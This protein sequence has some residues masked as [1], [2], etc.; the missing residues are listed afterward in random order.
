MILRGLKANFLGDSIT[1]G[2]GLDDPDDVYWRRLAIEDGV[3]ARGYGISGT[4][5]A[6]QRVEPSPD[7]KWDQYFRSRVP[8][9][10]PDADVVVVF[11]GT[12]DYG[13]G[14]APLGRMESRRDDT[15]YGALHNLYEDL[16]EKYPRSEIVVMTP[17]H[18]AAEHQTVNGLG[19]RNVGTLGDYVRII[20][21]VAA[22]YALPVLDLYTLSGIQPAVD[23]LRERYAP[24]GLHPNAAGQERI[25]R[26]LRSFL[27][28]L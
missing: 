2:Y 11:G 3:I 15:F 17:L 6:K 14:D 12:N 22:Y 25:Y 9:M 18:S 10:D 13:H 21:E 5:I 8:S 28:E 24:D 4:R 26:L 16:L 27:T 23:F 20:R 1:K 19:L 7:P